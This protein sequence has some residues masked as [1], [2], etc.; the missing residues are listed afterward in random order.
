MPTTLTTK[1]ENRRDKHGL[2]IVVPALN[3]RDNIAELIKRLHLTLKSLQKG[4]LK[5]EIIIV[6]DHST[7]DTYEYSLELTNRYP[8]LKVMLKQGKQGKAF[9]LLEGLTAA[10][11]DL[12]CI[13]DAD[14][15]YP[16]EAIR[17]MFEMVSSA[18]AD[19]VVARRNHQENLGR[20][21][22]SNSYHIIYKLLVRGIDVDIQSGLKLFKKAALLQ[23]DIKPTSWTFDFEFLLKSRN[24]GYRIAS[25]DIDFM[26]RVSGNSKIKFLFRQLR[27]SQQPDCHPDCTPGYVAFREADRK[28]YG[29]GF[30]HKGKRYI[31][32]N[33]LH[34]RFT[35]VRRLTISQ[36]LLVILLLVIIISLILFSLHL[37]VLLIISVITTLYFGDMLF[38]LF[39]IYRSYGKKLTIHIPPNLLDENADWPSYTVLCPLYKESNILPQFVDSMQRLDYP[40]DKLQ[41]LL[42]LESDDLETQETARSMHLP[43]QFQILIVPHS[44]PKTKPKACNYGLTKANGKY[45]LSMTLRTYP[46][47]CSS[48][49]PF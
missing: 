8:E 21:L 11:Y 44:E 1:L 34:P 18:K 5:F 20:K 27:N 16:P 33:E 6:D 49:R 24:A 17:G 47:P 28:K 10:K 14:L 39:L 3:E 40:K 22:I 41:I 35:A 19:I 13:I 37:A 45:E 29:S 32:H 25:Y 30:Y 23:A 12:L 36:I 46:I 9:S 42:L 31:T 15:Q 43:S 4:R 26:P 2:S 48:R 38:N 7:D